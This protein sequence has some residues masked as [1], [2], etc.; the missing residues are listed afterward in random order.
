MSR[1]RISRPENILK[2]VRCRFAAL[3]KLIYSLIACLW[4][5]TA[6]PA[7]IQTS[8]DTTA[9]NPAEP[10]SG[11]Q[12]SSQMEKDLQQLNWKQF[13]SV[14]ESVPKLKADVDAYGPLGWQ[15]VQA[16]YT[17]Y[18]WKKNIDRLDDA[19]KKQLADLIQAAKD[20]K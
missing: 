5:M 12:I 14:I 4:A 1:S 20:S 16:N 19:Q 2:A 8:G 13:R 9:A 15:Y 17:S 3:A 18:G 10:D 7:E 6:F 11:Q